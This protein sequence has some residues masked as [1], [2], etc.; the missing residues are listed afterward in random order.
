MGLDP[1]LLKV[2]AYASHVRQQG[3]DPYR[4]TTSKFAFVPPTTRADSGA[5][6]E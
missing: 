3:G 6:V 1:E 5:N 4:R 2:A